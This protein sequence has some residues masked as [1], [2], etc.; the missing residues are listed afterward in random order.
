VQTQFGWHVIKLEDT[1]P[2]Q[3]PPIEQVKDRVQQLVQRKRVAA[4]LEELRKTSSIDAEKL[5]AALTEHATTAK[6]AAAKASVEP[7]PE[8]APAEAPA[9]P[10]A[11]N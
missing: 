1:R 5:T 3:L 10:P 4:H 9:P 8:T 7:A 11:A 6:E 2:A